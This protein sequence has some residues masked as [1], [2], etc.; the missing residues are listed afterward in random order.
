MKSLLLSLAVVLLAAGVVTAQP[1]EGFLTDYASAQAQAKKDGKPM[2]LHFTT[3]WCKW[4]RTIEDDIYKTPEGQKVL[5]PF[6]KVSL[7]CT[8]PEGQQPSGASKTNLDLMQKFGGEGFPF[9]VITTSEGD[10][11]GRWSGYLP[12][13]QFQEQVDK[14]MKSYELF[15]KIKQCQAKNE[16]NTIEYHQDCLT[17]YLDTHDLKKAGQAADAL[18]KLDPKGEKTD[19]A[20]IAFAQLNAAMGP[21]ADLSKVEALHKIIIDADP[22]NEKGYLEKSYLSHVM[23]LMMMGQNKAPTDQ[24]AL[25]KQM[26]TLLQEMIQNVPTLSNPMQVYGL[27]F[28]IQAKLG[29]FDNAIGTLEALKKI[30]PEGV[31]SAAIDQTI[32]KLKEA[33][34]S[35]EQQKTPAAAPEAAA[36]DT[37]A[38]PGK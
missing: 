31:D 38:A 5:E 13:P 23:L 6:V 33:K 30:S 18:Q 22:K 29:E 35:M 16:T 20:Q 19:S 32:E 24:N 28:Q 21:N 9:L 14:A 3:A 11:L 37:K 2:Y 1:V 12:L 25:L 15:K 8:V 17:F 27:L 7:D 26:A 36:E 10:V 34:A 4:C